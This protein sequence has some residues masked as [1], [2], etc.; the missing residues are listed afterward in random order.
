VEPFEALPVELGPGEGVV[1]LGADQGA[2]VGDGAL[3]RRGVIAEAL[4]NG[5]G[6]E[7]RVAGLSGEAAQEVVVDGDDGA[8]D[9]LVRGEI[10]D[11]A[12]VGQGVFLSWW[13]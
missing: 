7:D 1:E 5:D 8:G 2:A 12:G 6:I 4:Q 11:G 13:T 3:A 9:L 10:V